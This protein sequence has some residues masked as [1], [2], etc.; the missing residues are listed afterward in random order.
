L[1]HLGHRY[2]EEVSLKN[3]GNRYACRRGDFVSFKTKILVTKEILYL[4]T[5]RTREIK[6]FVTF[7]MT[8]AE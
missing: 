6:I 7:G 8:H 2:A 4:A 3:L 5:F 1:Q